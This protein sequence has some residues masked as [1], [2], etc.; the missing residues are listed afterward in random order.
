MSGLLSSGGLVINSCYRGG[1]IRHY[2]YLMTAP[3]SPDIAV[4]S[5]IGVS[6]FTDIWVSASIFDH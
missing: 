3:G 2:L 1:I 5:T 6:S 4:A